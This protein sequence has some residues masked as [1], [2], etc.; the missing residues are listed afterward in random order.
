[1]LIFNFVIYVKIN[2]V[3]SIYTVTANIEQD[4][5]LKGFINYKILNQ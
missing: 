3:S 5:N 1:M 2:T 4:C